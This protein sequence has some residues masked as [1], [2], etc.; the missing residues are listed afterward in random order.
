V[1]PDDARVGVL[2]DDLAQVEQVPRGLHGPPPP[3]PP[4]RQLLE[5]AP[6]RAVQ[7]VRRLPE[8]PR[9]VVALFYAADRPIAEVA[10]IL[11]VPEGTVKSDLARARTVLM[12]ELER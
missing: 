3:G 10:S 8:R 6:V 11:N 4:P 12:A 2:G 1:G 9:L 7:A 5:D